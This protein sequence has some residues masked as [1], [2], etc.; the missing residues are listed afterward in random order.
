MTLNYRVI[1]LQLFDK[2]KP[3]F[4]IYII[5]T[6]FYQETIAQNLV[7]FDFNKKPLKLA[8][9]ELSIEY[10]IPIIFPDTT[11]NL[12]I[13]S[14]CNKCSE[15]EAIISVLSSTSLKWEK[16]KTQKKPKKI[17]KL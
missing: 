2:L 3:F 13:Y 7:S 6:P 15:T 12:P 4:K 14:K 8:L 9:L 11:P 16:N 1:L 5:L 10:D 17:P